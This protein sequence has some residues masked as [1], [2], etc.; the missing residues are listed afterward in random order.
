MYNLTPGLR[1]TE[2]P[3]KQQKEA[4]RWEW[5]TVSTL[6]QDTK[7]K[8][9]PFGC[10]PFADVIKLSSGSGTGI[11]SDADSHIQKS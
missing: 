7:V 5:M 9:L 1:N 6:P 10:G 4:K 3:M 11:A 8:A 2:T